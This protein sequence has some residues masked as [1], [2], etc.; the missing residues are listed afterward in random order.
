[1]A[2]SLT[3]LGTLVALV[4]PGGAAEP[5]EHALL[6]AWTAARWRRALTGAGDGW[7]AALEEPGASARPAALL[8]YVLDLS[9]AAL[10]P[11]L[12]RW[13]DRHTCSASCSCPPR[14]CI[15]SRSG[16]C[17]RWPRGPS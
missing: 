16:R 13:L 3:A 17:R 10:D 8:R 12:A 4:L 11:L 1:M 9:A 15:W 7:L 14:N 6:D 5:A 2:F